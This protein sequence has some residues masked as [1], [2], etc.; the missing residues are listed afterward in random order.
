MLVH[1]SASL[2]SIGVYWLGKMKTYMDICVYIYG[3]M[4]ICQ[5]CICMCMRILMF[6]NMHVCRSH[7]EGNGS[8]EQLDMLPDLASLP[9]VLHT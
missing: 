4:D 3:Y 7:F 8:L 5:T 9:G 6:I 1:H 2:N